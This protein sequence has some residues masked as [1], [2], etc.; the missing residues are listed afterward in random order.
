M[1]RVNSHRESKKF[2]LQMAVSIDQS[3]HF[4]KKRQLWF[5]L[6]ALL[7]Y[8][9]NVFKY[10]LLHLK[11][12]SHLSKKIIYFNDSPS[13]M[14][15]KTFYFILK[16]LFILKMFKF[17]SWLCGFRKSGLIRKIRLI[18]KLQLQYTY[19]SISHELKATRQQ[20]LVS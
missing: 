10:L 13:K 12:E 19:C 9:F 20:N 17:L 4:Q 11:S 8:S 2:L 6:I 16:A 14:M 15:N 1:I 18:S 7:M 3:K 5:M